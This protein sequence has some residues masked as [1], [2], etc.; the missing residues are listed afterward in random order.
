MLILSADLKFLDLQISK[1]CTLC[2]KICIKI[3]RIELLLL[4]VI[5]VFGTKVGKC[6]ELMSERSQCVTL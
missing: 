1:F 4:V 5:A 3:F 6:S 2:L